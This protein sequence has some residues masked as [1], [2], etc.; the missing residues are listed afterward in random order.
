MRS[1]DR[2]R[3][4]T[5]RANASSI[6]CA[7]AVRRAP[8]GSKAS[9][10]RSSPSVIA[11]VHSSATGT[12]C[13]QIK[14]VGSEGVTRASSD[15]MLVSS[16]IT[17]RARHPP[18]SGPE[19]LGG[20]RPPRLRNSGNSCPPSGL[21]IAT[22]ASASVSDTESSGALRFRLCARINHASSTS[23]RPWPAAS[24]RKRANVSA[25]RSRDH[26]GAH[27]GSPPYQ[28]PGHIPPLLHDFPVQRNGRKASALRSRS[29]QTGLDCGNWPSSL[30]KA[31]NCGV[32]PSREYD[33]K[34]AFSRPSRR[35]H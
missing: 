8:A 13:A 1:N 9:P 29:C 35:D 4:C 32:Q 6:A 19:K 20:G 7:S 26:K 15:N 14:T 33:V 23:D 12:A 30:T 21:K 25:S 31:H 2:T 16:K 24:A 18:Y 3:V 5:T 22:M 28:L 17:V 10:K 34:G 27:D 11:V